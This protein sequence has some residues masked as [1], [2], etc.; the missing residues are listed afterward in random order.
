MAKRRLSTDSGGS[1]DL[2]ERMQRNRQRAL[3]RRQERREQERQDEQR[4]ERAL[5]N[6]RERINS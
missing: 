5:R 6:R 1:G 2:F 3:T 4:R